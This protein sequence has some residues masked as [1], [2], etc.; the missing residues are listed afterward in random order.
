MKNESIMNDF[1]SIKDLLFYV[2]VLSISYI[3][4][5]YQLDP[6]N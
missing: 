4:D 3:L 6:Y 1:S 2:N 5:I